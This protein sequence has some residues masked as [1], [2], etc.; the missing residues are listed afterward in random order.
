M[1]VQIYWK[2]R[3][4]AGSPTLFYKAEGI[5]VKHRKDRMEEDWPHSVS[6]SSLFDDYKRWHDEVYLAPYK[7]FE[8]YQI[9]PEQMPS[10]ADQLNFFTTMAPWLYIV[11]K[12]QQTRNYACDTQVQVGGVWITQSKGRYFVRLAELKFHR[13]YFE[14]ITGGKVA[15]PSLYFDPQQAVVRHEGQMEFLRLITEGRREQGLS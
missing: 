6:R 11:S 12:Q 13:A 14:N 15:D 2:E 1:S 3:L 4:A 9:N 8:F 10:P 7:Q 5:D